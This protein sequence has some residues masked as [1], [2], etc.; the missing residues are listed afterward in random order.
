MES[1]RNLKYFPRGTHDFE[2]GIISSHV[3]SRK[4]KMPPENDPTDR[5][6]MNL[7]SI[8]ICH[9]ESYYSRGALAGEVV[10]K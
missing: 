3:V 6:V 2:I 10:N 8:A 4:K 1:I 7:I 9:M 5:H